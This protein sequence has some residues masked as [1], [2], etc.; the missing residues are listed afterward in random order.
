[1]L[2]QSYFKSSYKD[3]HDKDLFL[4]IK[5]LCDNFALLLHL[6]FTILIDRRNII[7]KISYCKKSKI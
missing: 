2:F 1:M 4:C 7:L 6:Y 3:E 5:W